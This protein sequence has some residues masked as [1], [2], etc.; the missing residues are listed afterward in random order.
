MP[1]V[2]LKNMAKSTATTLKHI[3]YCAHIS[4]DI[5]NIMHMQHNLVTTDKIDLSP[6]LRGSMDKQFSDSDLIKNYYYVQLGVPTYHQINTACNTA[7]IITSKRHCVKAMRYVHAWR[8]ET[9]TVDFFSGKSL[10][11]SLV[12]R[13]Q[14]ACRRRTIEYIRYHGPLTRYL[15]LLVAHAPAMPGTFSPP[16]RV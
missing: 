12:D 1:Q 11:R 5:F 2:T 16:P 3:I 4:W 8:L 13:R 7:A 15:K 6:F 14:A 9:D 10:S